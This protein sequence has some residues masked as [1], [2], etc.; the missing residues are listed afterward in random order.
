MI[1]LSK[2]LKKEKSNQAL[3]IFG[4]GNNGKSIFI[5]LLLDIFGDDATIKNI[6]ERNSDNKYFTVVPYYESSMDGHI[7]CMVDDFYNGIIESNIL[8]DNED[9]GLM[10][11]LIVIPFT[12]TFSDKDKI[13]TEAIKLELINLL[14]DYED[15]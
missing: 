7:K 6:D 1:Y 3:F 11:R 15:L 9:E 5:K 2:A 12:N 13:G 4:P 10:R 14:K 8:L